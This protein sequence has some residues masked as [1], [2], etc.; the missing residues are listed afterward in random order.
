MSDIFDYI[1][2]YTDEKIYFN[3]N[4]NK[5]LT[6]DDINYILEKLPNLRYINFGNNYNH[7]FTTGLIPEQITTIRL[8][9]IYT[10]NVGYKKNAIHTRCDIKFEGRKYNNL[11]EFLEYYP[12][13]ETENV[14]ESI[15]IP[16]EFLLILMWLIYYLIFILAVSHNGDTTI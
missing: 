12:E 13:F 9:P 4:F 6:N 16:E 10:N 3:K 2:R 14:P 15:G 7:E 8:S 11:E 1:R 5:K